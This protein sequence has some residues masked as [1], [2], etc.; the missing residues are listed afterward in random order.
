MDT[1]LDLAELTLEQEELT[2]EARIKDQKREQ[3][4]TLFKENMETLGYIMMASAF[5]YL[6][7]VRKECAER[8]KKT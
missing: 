6:N 3:R 2:R 4:W 5:V 7:Y 1:D 8:N